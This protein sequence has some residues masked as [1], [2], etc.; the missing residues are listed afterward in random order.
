[1]TPPD[2]TPTVAQI[3][4]LE[5]T[6]TVTDGGNEVGTFNSTTRPTDTEVMNLAGI[7]VLMLRGQPMWLQ[8][9]AIAALLTCLLIEESYF[10]DANGVAVFRDLL[11]RQGYII[12][13]SGAGGGE[14]VNERV[15]DSVLM[16]SGMTEYDPYYPPPIPLKDWPYT[17][18]NP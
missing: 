14:S 12:P 4:A 3:S 10:R 9:Q 2:I 8:T 6:R 7:A 5:R 11:M 18:A 17:G 1:M 16:R 13:L 15:I